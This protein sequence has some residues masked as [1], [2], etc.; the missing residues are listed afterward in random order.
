MM[1][2]TMMTVVV[3]MVIVV[4]TARMY[5]C[6]TVTIQD[7]VTCVYCESQYNQASTQAHGV[8]FITVMVMVKMMEMVRDVGIGIFTAMVIMLRM[9][10]ILVIN[11]V[12][13]GYNI[14]SF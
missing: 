5:E 12:M 8:Q 7:H 10:I 3:E 11:L 9:V 1:M 2:I 4:Y 14:S 13:Q 6:C